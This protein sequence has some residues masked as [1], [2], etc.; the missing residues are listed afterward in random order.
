MQPK[1]E[2]L[3]LQPSE[4]ELRLTSS[5]LEDCE[6]VWIGELSEYIMETHKRR[7]QVE[8][9]FEASVLVS[10]FGTFAVRS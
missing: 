1:L 3:P 4:E 7:K 10:F 6:E 5:D 9:W 8:L 2:E